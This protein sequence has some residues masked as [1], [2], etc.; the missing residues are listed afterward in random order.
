MRITLVP[1]AGA[2][3]GLIQ[4]PQHPRDAV[5]HGKGQ[6]E[7]VD[8][9]PIIAAQ[10]EMDGSQGRDR[11]R[12]AQHLQVGSVLTESRGRETVARGELLLLDVRQPAEWAAGHAPGAIHVPGAALPA[13]AAGVAAA[14]GAGGGIL[15]ST[16][17]IGASLSAPR[18]AAAVVAAAVL[19]V[20]AWYVWQRAS[21]RELASFLWTRPDRVFVVAVIACA[22]GMYVGYAVVIWWIPARLLFVAAPAA[23]VLLAVAT[24]P[25]RARPV[26][27]AVLGLFVVVNAWLLVSLAGPLPVPVLLDP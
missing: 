6:R 22:A 27:W 21:R 25:R 5:D 23:A 19:V 7:A 8:L 11:A 4:L 16:V 18:V 13:C 12:G 2:S 24:H 9:P 20:G 10:A 1:A 17:T 3:P 15:P 14:G 26:A